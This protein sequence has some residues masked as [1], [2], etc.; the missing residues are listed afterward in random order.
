MDAARDQ[1]GTTDPRTSGFNQPQ[2]LRLDSQ[3]LSSK[4]QLKGKSTLPKRITSNSTFSVCAIA[5]LLVVIA[6]LERHIRNLTSHSMPPAAS[7]RIETTQGN[8]R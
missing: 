7:Q 1:R 4:L 8:G 6:L 5:I 3:A 2:L